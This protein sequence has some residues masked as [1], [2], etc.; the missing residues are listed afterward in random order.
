MGSRRGLEFAESKIQFPLP[1]KFVHQGADHEGS[2]EA[3]KG[4]HGHR[5]GPQKGQGKVA[6]VL[7]ASIIVGLVIKFFHELENRA[8][9]NTKTT[10]PGFEERAAC[11]VGPTV[12]QL[13]AQ[14]PASSPRKVLAAISGGALGRAL[15]PLVG[16]LPG[17]FEHQKGLTPLFPSVGG[18]LPPGLL[19]TLQDC[20]SS[21]CVQ[22]GPGSS[23][24]PCA[25]QSPGACAVSCGCSPVPLLE[26]PSCALP[27][28][29][30]TLVATPWGPAHSKPTS[31]FCEDQASLTT[32][33]YLGRGVNRGHIV[34][35]L[36][37]RP[38]GRDQRGQGKHERQPLRG[39]RPRRSQ[40]AEGPHSRHRLVEDGV[41]PEDLSPSWA[42]C[43]TSC[44]YPPG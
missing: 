2:D 8:K 31:L 40:E 6:Q 32:S 12:G 28:R 9:Q 11:A 36:E 29:R 37:G 10:W 13:G 21:L 19:H 3:S 33:T 43:L 4:E 22:P 27:M 18:P 20:N 26:D 38:K 24:W 7:T 1:A 39:E 44:L 23:P 35:V 14:I 25:C 15:R 30:P 16:N 17:R 41:E 5:N 42:P 34:P